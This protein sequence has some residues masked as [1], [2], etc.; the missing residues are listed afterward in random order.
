MT[1][2][3]A[4]WDSPGVHHKM[5]TTFSSHSGET[6]SATMKENV[7]I[8]RT[9]VMPVNAIAASPLWRLTEKYAAMVHNANNRAPMR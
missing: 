7:T 6:K 2:G 5:Y 8:I 4:R 3:K 9:T 1:S